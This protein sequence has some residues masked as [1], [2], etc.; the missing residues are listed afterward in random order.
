MMSLSTTVAI[1]SLL[2]VV[3]AAAGTDRYRGGMHVKCTRLPTDLMG[4]FVR[5]GDGS[6]LAADASEVHVSRDDG[7]TWES[8]PLFKDPT[9][10][11]CRRER[12]VLRTRDGVVLIAFMNQKEL[13]SH[14]R[15]DTETTA[16]NAYPDHRLPVYVVRSTNDGKTWLK[17]RPVQNE[18]WCGAVRD[19]IQTSTGR[20]ILPSQVGWNDP[21][22]HIALSYASDDNGK[23]WTRSNYIDLGGAGHHAGAIEPTVEELRDGRIYMLIRTC[24]DRFWEAISDDGG[25]HWRTIRPSAIDASG[26]P[27]LLKRLA[28]G[29]LCLVWNRLYPKGKKSTK[30]RS[31]AGEE[32]PTSYHRNEL[33]IAFS[34]D[35]GKT[36]SQPVVFAKGGYNTYPYVYEHQPGL[37]WITTFVADGL[38]VS[39]REEDFLR[40]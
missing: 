15:P 18:G 20:I 36:W 5:L 27:G 11:E 28:S 32:V 26:S 8:R 3:G 4:P 35:D 1:F 29:R 9:K 25:L 30:R 34:D 13:H 39:L 40:K 38:R 17:P 10:F 21:L 19:M 22:R 2:L 14:R 24:Y 6:V 12:A 31:G 16:G 7:K 37:L 33:S 23:T